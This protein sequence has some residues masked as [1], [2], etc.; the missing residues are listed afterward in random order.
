MKRTAKRLVVFALCAALVASGLAAACLAGHHCEGE[1]CPICLMIQTIVRPAVL[2]PTAAV[3]S[4][5]VLRTARA[6]MPSASRA[7][8]CSSL[9]DMKTELLS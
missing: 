6:G 8:L 3:L 9:V 7:R 2:C 5:P 1:D 4:A